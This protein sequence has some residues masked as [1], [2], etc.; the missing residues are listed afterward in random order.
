MAGKE[1]I[2]RKCPYCGSMITYDEY[3]C[4]ACHKRLGDQQTQHPLPVEADGDVEDRSQRRAIRAVIRTAYPDAEDED[5]GQPPH[6]KRAHVY[7]RKAAE[8][9][10]LTYDE[11]RLV[12][13]NRLG[14]EHVADLTPEQVDVL[15]AW[16]EPF[17][18]SEG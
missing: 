8:R 17:V 2:G 7:L 4:R 9:M 5:A 6:T 13:L 18:T 1:Q 3:F 14:A 15:V 10:G 12:A 16:L 11:L